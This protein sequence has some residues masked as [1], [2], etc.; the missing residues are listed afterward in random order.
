MYE[1]LPENLADATVSTPVPK[2]NRQLSRL[3]P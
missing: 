2:A 3:K 1:C